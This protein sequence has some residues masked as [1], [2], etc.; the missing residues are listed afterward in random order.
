MLVLCMTKSSSNGWKFFLNSEPLSYN[1]FFG[2][3]YLANQTSSNNLDVWAEDLCSKGTSAI[4]NQPVAGSMKA[5]HWSFNLLFLIEPSVSLT[6]IIMVYVP[7]R[8]T[9]TVCQGSNSSGSLAA[10][11]LY[12]CYMSEVTLL[13]SGTFLTKV[14]C[15]GG[16]SFPCAD[17][18]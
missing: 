1:T 8:S 10:R 12:F 3:G 16:N 14:S 7:I 17:L 9:H 15:L 4:S 6:L 11:C 2:W 5:I 13:K 18:L